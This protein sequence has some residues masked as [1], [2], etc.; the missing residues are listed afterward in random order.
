MSATSS[1]HIGPARRAIYPPAGGHSAVIRGRALGHLASCTPGKATTVHRFC[2]RSSAL[3]VRKDKVAPATVAIELLPGAL[4]LG[5]P[6]GDGVD[7]RWMMAEA[8]VAAIDLDV[9]DLGPVLVQAGLPGADAVR[10]AEDGGGRHRRRLGQ[11]IKQVV[12]FDLAA[13]HD[14]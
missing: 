7:D 4:G 5:E 12:V 6:V 13:A 14:L 2:E 3:P 11:R 1:S 10:A 8:A 9:L